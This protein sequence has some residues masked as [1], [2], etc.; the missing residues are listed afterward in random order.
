M[1]LLAW[2]LIGLILSAGAPA[3]SIALQLEPA[4][5]PRAAIY[6]GGPGKDGIPAILKPAF[7]AAH[8]A[9]FLTPTDRV[10]GFA[11][12][13]E[14]RAY[15]LQILTWHEVVNDRVGGQPVLITY[16]PL[17][18]SVVA[19]DPRVAGQALTFG[20]SGRL[21]QSN[22][23]MYDHQSESLWSQLAERAVTGPH[24]ETPLAVLPVD[25]TSWADWRTRHPDS[26]VLSRETGHQRDYDRDPYARYAA[27]PTTMF[28]TE[29]DDDRLPAKDWVVG[30]RADGVTRAYPVAK[31]PD[32][33]AVTDVLGGR[34]I[35]LT[36][37]ARAESVRVES[38]DARSAPT[39]I[40][41]YWFAWAAFHPTTEVWTEPE[42]KTKASS[43]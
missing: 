21:Y 5:I 24:N 13:G 3:R 41:A 28:P 4:S 27:S 1:H 14:A 31:L 36:R 42:S 15:P 18:G 29:R 10:A 35:R 19:F 32:G 16:C 33:E 6:D 2:G 23:L 7:V 26:K 38:R 11:H 34:T 12:G 8:E 20:V 37:N 30:V 17:T 25:V 43:P 40:V 39:S 22:V 9:E